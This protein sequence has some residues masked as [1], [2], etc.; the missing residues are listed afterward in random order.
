MQNA[1]MDDNT[2]TE[3][4]EEKNKNTDKDPSVILKKVRSQK[5]GFSIFS[6]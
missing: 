4:H 3:K 6:Y 5:S 1:K 2:K